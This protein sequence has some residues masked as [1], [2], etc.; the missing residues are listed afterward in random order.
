MTIAATSPTKGRV[1]E[2]FGRRLRAEREKRSLSQ[3]D[4]A[5]RSVNPAD[6]TDR[7]SMS[8]IS[9]LERNW[10]AYKISQQMLDAIARGLGVE[11]WNVYE[12]AGWEVPTEAQS[13]VLEAIT[14]DPYLSPRAKEALR[15]MYAALTSRPQVAEEAG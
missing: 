15:D 14:D 4:L 12:W 9:A 5:E 10:Q 6:P 2:D 7:I 11:P 3:A 8:Y 13:N 1:T